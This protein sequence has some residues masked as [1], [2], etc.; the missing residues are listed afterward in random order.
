MTFVY[1]MLFFG[2][3]RYLSSILATYILFIILFLV[4]LVTLVLPYHSLVKVS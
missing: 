2:L 1:H 3:V 4:Y